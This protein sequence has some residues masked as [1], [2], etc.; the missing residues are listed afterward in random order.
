MCFCCDLFICLFLFMSL[1]Y[2]S[3]EKEAWFSLWEGRCGTCWMPLWSMANW[4]TVGHVTFLWKKQWYQ[5]TR[6]QHTF[7]VMSFIIR[8]HFSLKFSLLNSILSIL[9]NFPLISSVTHQLLSPILVP[10]CL[11]LQIRYCRLLHFCKWS[12]F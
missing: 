3:E 7:A 6:Y 11:I 2:Q 9:L 8:S 5:A 1:K 12:F 10:L 4:V